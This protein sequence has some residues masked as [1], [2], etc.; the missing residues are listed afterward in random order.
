M[1][2]VTVPEETKILIGEAESVDFSEPFAHEK[3]SPVLGM[4][5]IK[6]LE[7]GI[8]KASTVLHVCGGEG[9]TSGLHVD[10][11]K[12]D[13]IKKFSE[14]MKTCRIVINSPTAQ[15]G[16]GDMYNFKLAPSLTLGCG[17][18]AGN[19]RSENIGVCHLLNV[20]TVA[21]RRENMLW[22]RTPEKLYHKKGCMQLA[23]R[24]LRDEYHCKK[25]FIVT[26]TFLY[27][28]G[29]TKPIEEELDRIGIKHA[30]FYEVAP[31]PTLQIARVGVKQLAAFQP[32][33]I[34]A[35]G[36]GS[37]MDAAKIMWLM[38]E[39]PEEDFFNLASVFIDI[40]KRIH[41]FP[42]MGQKAKLVC[43]PTSAGTGSEVT[44]FAIITDADTGTKWP[45]ADYELMPTMA[46]VDADNM[47][48]APKGLTSAS[49]IDVLT[50][51]TE[52]FV[53]TLAT[54]YTDGFAIKATQNVMKY[55]KR[56]Y[57]NG[58]N[59]IEARVKMADAACMAGVAFANAFLGIC[60]SMAHKLGAYHHLPHGV[61]NALLMCEVMKYNASECPWKM[62]TFSQY[63]YPKG[64]ERYAELA[65][66]CGIC[67]KD[68]K[69]TFDLFIAAIE[70]LKADVGIKPCIQAYG[71]DEAYFLEKLDEMVEAAFNDQCTGA[72]PVYPKMSDM[73][74]M[75]LRAYYGK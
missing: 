50:H 28:N 10:L 53:A 66:Y 11:T 75:Y 41:K 72:N 36:G 30:C 61:A 65:R 68:D 58:P 59:D 39:H 57:D 32:D 74:A 15:G 54:D 16:I 7:D 18:W 19:S 73:K 40:R 55:L 64:L 52:A 12:T 5:K 3:L 26:D 71:V 25:A 44:P 38:Y 46:I 49:G 35:L 27:Q 8:Q 33:V 47:M 31:D 60:H 56:A 2:G 63:K 22:L 1:A 13:K 37:S 67:G 24:E 17:S 6:D 20:K 43:I 23:L 51:A 70:Q 62:G 42:K 4:Y 29:Y 34:I 9:H 45:L 14:A 48:T 69:E 21:E